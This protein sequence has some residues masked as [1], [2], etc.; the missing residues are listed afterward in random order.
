VLPQLWASY[1]VITGDV[2]RAIAH[3]RDAIA[4]NPADVQSHL[5]AA[6]IYRQAARYDLM[7]REAHE[8]LDRTPP[9]RRT[10]MRQIIQQLLG[11]TALDPLDDEAVATDDA[12]GDGSTEDATGEPG[13]L[14]LDSPLLGG[15]DDGPNLL[16]G[17]DDGASLL[18]DDAPS[19]LGGS[20]GLQLGGGGGGGLHL[21][22]SE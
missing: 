4:Q 20:Q 5:L 1:Y 14:T 2:D 13:S 9:T 3:A 22:L 15:S 16:G 10:E 6:R 17:A 21:N 19:L 8:V 18:G 11:P 12:S 7:R